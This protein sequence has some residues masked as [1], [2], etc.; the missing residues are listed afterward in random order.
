MEWMRIPYCRWMSVFIFAV[1]FFSSKASL[2]EE[3]TCLRSLQS[4]S[5]LHSTDNHSPRIFSNLP[6]NVAVFLNLLEIVTQEISAI[7]SDSFRSRSQLLDIVIQNATPHLLIEGSLTEKSHLL[8]LLGNSP[9]LE[10]LTASITSEE[11]RQIQRLA[12]EKKNELLRTEELHQTKATFSESDFLDIPD[13]HGQ[14]RL[15]RLLKDRKYEQAI[16]L[17]KNPIATTRYVNTRDEN[18]KTPL[19]FFERKSDIDGKGNGP[20]SDENADAKRVEKVAF[21]LKEKLALTGKKLEHFEKDYL[22]EIKALTSR[23]RI[24]LSHQFVRWD[25]PE[26]NL[27]HFYDMGGNLNSLSAEG[28]NLV[29]YFSMAGRLEELRTLHK[30][31][32]DFSLKTNEGVTAL[33]FAANEGSYEVFSFL[34]ESGI[35]I[36]AKSLGGKTPIFYLGHR[37]ILDSVKTLVELGADLNHAIPRSGLTPAHS[38]SSRNL[39]THLSALAV[40]GANFEI[41][42]KFGRKPLDFLGIGIK[43]PVFTVFANYFLSKGIDPASRGLHQTYPGAATYTNRFPVW[44]KAQKE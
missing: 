30:M 12:I 18:G 4:H 25:S 40:H 27:S 17:L 21:Y 1:V 10:S 28:R 41:P 36:N 2:T 22:N 31:G 3:F 20:N 37:N 38:Y 13:E 15:H 29:I 34:V 23:W 7:E 35:D 44:K 43:E 8:S 11:W 14:V 32:A 16:A 5:G 33:H 39:S 9:A 6:K 42:D 26:A 19:D 24:L